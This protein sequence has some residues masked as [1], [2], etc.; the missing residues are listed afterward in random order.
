MVQLF[1]KFCIDVR[2]VGSSQSSISSIIVRGSRKH[3]GLN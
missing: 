1:T 2:E 3:G